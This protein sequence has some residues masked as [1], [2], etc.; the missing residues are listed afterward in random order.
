METNNVPPNRGSSGSFGNN[1]KQTSGCTQ[2]EP[3]KYHGTLKENLELLFVTGEQ[4]YAD[5][6]PLMTE[7]SGAFVTMVSCYLAPTPMNW[8]RQFVTDWDRNHIARTWETFK[9]AMRKCFLPPDFEYMLREKLGKLTQIGSLCDYVSVFQDVL[10]PY[11]VPISPL[12]SRFYSQQGLH[13]ETSR[14]LRE[15]HPATLEEAIE[16]AMR[17]DYG[18]LLAVHHQPLLSG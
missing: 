5:Y 11:K 2:A 4:Y 10:D 12:E 1:Y 17:F 14:H 9:T 15:H 8:Y 13:S 3:P 7:N 6:H 18:A 16:L